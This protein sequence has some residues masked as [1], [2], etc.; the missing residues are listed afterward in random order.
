MESV[1]NFGDNIKNQFSNIGESVKGRL[2]GLGLSTQD[3]FYMYVVM[4]AFVI[5]IIILIVLGVMM[6]ELQSKTLFPPTQNACPDYWE[7]APNGQCKFPS[8]SNAKN[9]GNGIIEIDT[10]S[11]GIN[12]ISVNTPGFK[13]WAPALRVNDGTNYYTAAND[14]Q[15]AYQFVSLSDASGTAAMA[16]LYPGLTTRCAQKK[17]AVNNNIVWDGV[18][19]FTG[20]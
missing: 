16:D 14:T 3:P 17:W 7:L 20:C 15:K 10:T 1:N 11:P 18:T 19:N 12:A 13:T 2:S 4:G 9:V 5:L 6:T 8:Q